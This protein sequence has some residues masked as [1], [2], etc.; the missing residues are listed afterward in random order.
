[1]QNKIPFL[2]AIAAVSMGL[3]QTNVQALS[4]KYDD[5]IVVT[6]AQTELPR[7]A[8]GSAITVITSEDIDKR[9]TTL[10]GDLLREVTGLAVNQSGVQGTTTQV[11]I[12][13]AEGNHTV[14]LIDGIQVSNPAGSSE[15]N[16]G[17]LTTSNI[18]RIE[19]L[20]GAQ[21]ALWG[22]EAIGGVINII[23]KKATS[24][25]NVQSDIEIGSHASKKAHLSTDYANDL[26]Q[27]RFSS[28]IN[29]SNGTNIARTGS[30]D[31]GFH[32][33]TYD[34][35][36]KVTPTDNL[37]IDLVA[38][39]VDSEV[40]TD[41]QPGNN[42]ADGASNVS[43]NDQMFYKGKINLDLFNKFWTQEI[44]AESA[45]TYSQSFSSTFS[46]NS[47]GKRENFAYKS[48]FNYELAL[49][50]SNHSSSFLYEYE[51]ETGRGT[52]LGGGT[53]V[54]FITKSYALE[55]NAS[56]SE[57]FFITAG[58]RHDNN[59]F[60]DDADTFRVAGSYIYDKTN[61]RPH[62]SFGTAVKNP[63]ISELFGNFP[64]SNFVGNANL[65][66]EKSKG[67]DFGIE[68][69]LFEDALIIDVTYF[70]NLIEDLIQVT[71]SFSAN[72][73]VANANGTNSIYGIETS[74][75]TNLNYGISLLANY[76][77]TN[78]K[79]ATGTQLARRAR[80]IG[81]VNINYSFLNDKANI[82]LGLLFN[83]K[84][85]ESFPAGEIN[86]SYALVNLNASYQP[87]ENLKF[88]SRV[89]N[90]LDKEYEEVFSYRGNEF[91]VF[92]GLKYQY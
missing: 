6:A 89:E 42:V 4:L 25:F 70:R 80:H 14:V 21:S 34:A 61:T 27:L 83:G 18:E 22:S 26:I 88:Y 23:T 53:E 47:T 30:E 77:Y 38:R 79:N 16:F 91:G 19:V 9:G 64:S 17:N 40:E 63:T 73:T 85:R 81:S 3:F 69:S 52:F 10:V 55:H 62:F 20:R 28:Q 82:N 49:L 7:V 51:D 39:H 74:L 33:R 76:T 37:A 2:T 92:A 5:E 78:A 75:R 66:P 50:N 11:R 8:V 84:Q 46:S 12:R 58:Y 65:T 41:P 72:R 31:D 24:G 44:S 15:F 71:N 35:N 36:I 60:F 48:S 87:N 90:L 86:S 32:N 57:Q 1:M 29:R 45:R 54:G 13:G 56:F 59:T 67:W 68:Q 43:Y